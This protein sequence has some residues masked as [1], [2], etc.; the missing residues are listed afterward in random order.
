MAAV[1]ARRRPVAAA[2]A[3]ALVLF[4][5]SGWMLAHSA[6]F[7]PMAPGLAATLAGRG[8]A[9]VARALGSEP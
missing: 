1:D 9:A 6:V 4:V 8:G 7:G 3:Y 5:L 2:V